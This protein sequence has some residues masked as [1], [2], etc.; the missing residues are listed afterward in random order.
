[1]GQFCGGIP[2]ATHCIE[3][4]AT[5]VTDQNDGLVIN[6]HKGKTIEILLKRWESSA[7]HLLR[8][9]NILIPMHLHFFL[10]LVRHELEEAI[11]DL[12]N[13]HEFSGV[14][15]DVPEVLGVTTAVLRHTNH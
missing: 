9:D 4:M 5:F 15:E 3:R 11:L 6:T 8:G 14:F 7:L 13:S 1:M 2:L 12:D 10:P